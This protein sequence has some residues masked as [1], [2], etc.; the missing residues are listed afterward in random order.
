MKVDVE[1]EEYKKS[2]E[3]FKVAMRHIRGVHQIGEELALKLFE[4]GEMDFAK[5]LMINVLQHDISKLS[6]PLEY[7]HLNDAQGEYFKLAKNE[8]QQKNSH[9]P[10]YWGGIANMPELAIAEMC[11]DWYARAREKGSSLRDWIKVTATKQFEF[12]TK[13]KVY[14]SIKK[15]VDMLLDPM[16]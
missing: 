12:N 16:F 5:K 4:K 6:S 10:E 11:I 9:H 2:S 15:Y 1:S 8:H 13:S 14:K 7:E 3:N